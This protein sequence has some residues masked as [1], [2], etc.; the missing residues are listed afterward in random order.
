MQEKLERDELRKSQA[1]RAREIGSGQEI[2][3]VLVVPMQWQLVE[4]GEIGLLWSTIIL[5]IK[6]LG[7][8]VDDKKIK[9]THKSLCCIIFNFVFMKKMKN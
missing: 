2:E 6:D 7:A 1:Q 9:V 4:N 5:N 3:A 8:D